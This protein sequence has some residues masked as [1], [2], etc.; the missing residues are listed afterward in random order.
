MRKP[1]PSRR[2]VRCCGIS[3][4]SA[5]GY[6]TV[7]LRP[8][9][10]SMLPPGWPEQLLTARGTVTSR[11]ARLCEL[12]VSDL[13]VSGA[14]LQLIASG[15]HRMTVHATDRMTDQLD[16]LQLELGEGPGV[17]VARSASPALEDHLT[18]SGAIRWPWFS[19]AAVRLGAGA[20]Y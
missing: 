6:A 2:T 16:D 17:D 13:D 1:P 18:G 10:R 14:S 20:A 9:N 19:P 4:M 3:A 12:C 8:N 11:V 7:R 15:P 5:P